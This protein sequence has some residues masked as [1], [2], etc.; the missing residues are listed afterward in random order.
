MN[1]VWAV[2]GESM[3]R[4]VF[5]RKKNLVLLAAL[6]GVV[7]S[8]CNAESVSSPQESATEMQVQG[9]ELQTQAVELP[10]KATSTL[11]LNDEDFIIKDENNYIKL[12]DKYEEL[13]TNESLISISEMTINRAYESYIYESFA[14]S[15]GLEIFRITINSPTLE[16][17]R[18]IR[19]GDSMEKVVAQ[20]EGVDVYEVHTAEY[21]MYSHERKILRFRFDD[22]S[23]VSSI[24]I[25]FL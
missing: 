21:C 2:E 11:Q 12:G 5:V 15:V 4:A 1:I 3:R 22:N 24:V 18:G 19:V 16:T 9:T 10:T 8:G 23:K 6:V 17:A 7:V 20:Y 13:V 25:E 14:V